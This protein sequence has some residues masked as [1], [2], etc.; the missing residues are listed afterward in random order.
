MKDFTSTCG[1]LFNL[2]LVFPPSSQE[3][4]LAKQIK[5]L[6]HEFLPELEGE[7][8]P[9]RVLGY[10]SFPTP[11]LEDL[12]WLSSKQPSLSQTSAGNLHPPWTCTWK[13]HTWLEPGDFRR[14]HWNHVFKMKTDKTTGSGAK[15]NSILSKK[16]EDCWQWKLP[17]LLPPPHPLIN[18]HPCALRRKLTQ[19]L[20]SRAIEH[21]RDF[22]R[23]LWPQNPAAHKA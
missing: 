3:V 10:G 1:I 18:A 11:W 9:W 17:L 14:V 8:F 21:T 20:H 13:S 22:W 16:R 4:S 12:S 2:G 15:E 5:I 7:L 6:R 23:L 19:A